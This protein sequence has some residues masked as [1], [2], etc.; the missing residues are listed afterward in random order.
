MEYRTLGKT[1]WRVSALSFG[2]SS[3]GS[4]F[5]PIDESEGIRAVH[6]ALD[7]GVN[8][9]D[10]SPYYGRTTAETALG[11]ALKTVP[12]DRYLLATKVGRYD[13]A[14]FDFSANRVMSSVD[15]SLRRLGVDHIDLIQCHDIEFG[16]LD[17]IVSETLPALR[18]LQDAGKV[19]A[20]GVTGLPLTIFRYVL[21]R[22]ETDTILS[23][24][25]YS[26][27][28]TA[29]EG[30]LPYL[31]SKE[32]GVITASPLAMRLLSRT[33][34]PEWH[35]ALVA[36][37]EACAR[38]AAYCASKGADISKLAVQFA[39]RNP[40]IHTVVVGTANPDNMRRNIAWVDEPLDET[41][42]SEVLA[43]LAPVKNVTW[44]S[45]RP[46]NN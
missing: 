38:A 17:Q 40:A 43:I 13:K 11:K 4:E 7:N 25:R 41:L 3:L 26:L 8:F 1:G 6:V 10:V 36:V 46:E 9:I 18:R 5:R 14:L 16:S 12:R 24:C 22:A 45:G 15:E 29:L 21:D 19:R 33:G 30:E 42:L 44:R 39:V 37:K 31:Q 2:A 35:P 28:D 32:V 20:V 34:P 23:Y 27:N